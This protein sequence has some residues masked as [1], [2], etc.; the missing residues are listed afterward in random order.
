MIRSIVEVRLD[1]LSDGT[2]RFWR[3]GHTCGT[4]AVRSHARF[5]ALLVS[6]RNLTYAFV[7]GR[8]KDDGNERQKK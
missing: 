1:S 4:G 8:Q 5:V 3:G 2:G 7:A 6:P